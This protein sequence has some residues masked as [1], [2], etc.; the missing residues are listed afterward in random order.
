VHEYDGYLV[1]S[2]FAG[3]APLSQAPQAEIPTPAVVYFRPGLGV[4]VLD[5]ETET[6]LLELGYLP[7]QQADSRGFRLWEV[8]GTAHADDYE[9]NLGAG[10]DGSGAEGLVELESMLHPPAVIPAAGITCAT[11]INTG[12]EHYVLDAAQY[13]LNRWV[14]TG[15]APPAPPLLKVNT[16]TSPPTFVA[17]ANGNV[18]GGV[19]TPAVDVP[20]ATLFG[21]GQSGSSFCFL[22]GTTIPF[23]V[24][25]LA[26]L[27]PAHALFAWR[28]AVDTIADMRAGFIRP[29]DAAELIAAAARSDVGG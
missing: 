19:R 23:S 6:D 11:P 18:E 10:D 16:A 4:P 17:D 22:F 24:A 26:A 21:I 29:A 8:A 27:Y 2:R 13:W 20:V 28:W 3:S 7:A 9:T 15:Q 5:V 1:H 14:R 12:E 25:K